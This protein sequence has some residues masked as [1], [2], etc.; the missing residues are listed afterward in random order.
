MARPKL[1][2]NNS[3]R[4]MDAAERH[5]R[6]SGYNAFSFRDLA[7]EVGIKSSSVHYYFPTKTDLAAAVARRYTDRFMATLEG[8]DP[9]A[10]VQTYKKAFRKAYV[11]D[12]QMCLCGVLA[13][14]SAAL[15]KVVAR[16][17]KRFFD[18]CL[19]RL[20][21]RGSGAVSRNA[22]LGVMAKLEG[23]LLLA[24]V[25]RSVGAFDKAT[26]SLP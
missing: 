24:R 14:E 21:K 18:M 8:T 20:S 19:G 3:E 5:I 7:K 22:A 4:L 11:T 6:Q 2:S 25:Y 12:G 23:A 15:P 13:S 1:R 16:E 17:A 9:S 10:M 26:S